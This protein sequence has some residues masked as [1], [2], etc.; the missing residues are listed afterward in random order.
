[1]RLFVA[2]TPDREAQ[3]QLGRRALELQRGLGDAASLLRWTPAA[4]IHATLHFLGEIDEAR[5]EPL[6]AALGHSLPEPPFE[7]LL[8]DAGVFPQSGPPR[9]LWLAISN[10]A[11]AVRRLHHELG[12]RLQTAGVA[13]EDREFSPHVTM[14]R[15]RD[16][17]DRR[18]IARVRD[19]LPRGH[20]IPIAWVVD[21]VTLYRSDLSG[22]APRYDAIHHVRLEAAPGQR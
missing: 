19:R 11:A 22:P 1:V 8:G 18:E 16:R 2:L 17:S 3:A 12:T 9:V 13:L 6:R 21:R 10:G 15:A 5:L 14:A 7:I 20:E 4:N